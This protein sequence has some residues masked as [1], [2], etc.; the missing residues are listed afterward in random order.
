MSKVMWLPRRVVN[1]NTETA[2]GWVDVETYPELEKYCV[3][4]RPKS[5]L[6]QQ[7]RLERTRAL[8]SAPPRREVIVPRPDE[9]GY[10]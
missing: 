7:E 1:G 8:L 5:R 3:A 4:E 9:I 2:P 10:T 6:S